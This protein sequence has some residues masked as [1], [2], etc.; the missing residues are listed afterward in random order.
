M[1]SDA[2]STDP[3]KTG[4]SDT[5]KTNETTDTSAPS[6]SHTSTTTTS[7]VSIARANLPL[8]ALLV[9]VT[10]VRHDEDRRANRP[11][12]LR[13]V[14]LCFCLRSGTFNAQDRR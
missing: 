7:T 10:S 2:P 4:L 14:T 9:L 12:S 5:N 11:S 3:S 1:S 13:A 8:H 6:D